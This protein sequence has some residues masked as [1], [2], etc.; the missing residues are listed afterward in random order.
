V[1]GQIDHVESS[2]EVIH[3]LVSGYLDAVE[4]LNGLAPR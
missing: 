3:R 2:R 4:R 1:I